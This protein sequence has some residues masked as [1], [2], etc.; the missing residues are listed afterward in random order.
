[1]GVGLRLGVC[2]T[3]GAVAALFSPSSAGA[4]V[5]ALGSLCKACSLAL[6][7]LALNFLAW[8]GI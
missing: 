4:R 8:F 1:M 6:E 7:C 5:E 2:L 3:Q